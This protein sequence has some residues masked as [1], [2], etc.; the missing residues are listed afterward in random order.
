VTIAQETTLTVG[1]CLAYGL[2][3]CSIPFLD[4]AGRFVLERWIAHQHARRLEVA[5]RRNQV[6]DGRAYG[7]E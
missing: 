7:E 2:M 5:E 6:A 3:I 4:I 1:I